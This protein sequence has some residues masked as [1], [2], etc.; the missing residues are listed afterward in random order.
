[1]HHV[2]NRINFSCLYFRKIIIR[3]RVEGKFPV[4]NLI[5][6]RKKDFWFY[7]HNST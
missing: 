2:W 6:T 4:G 3:N 5:V 7:Q 1:M